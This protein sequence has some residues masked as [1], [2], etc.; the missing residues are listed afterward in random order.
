MQNVIG[1]K[2][3]E[4]LDSDYFENTTVLCGHQGM[5]HYVTKVNV[6]EVPDIINWVKPGEFLLTTAYSIRHDIHQL[7]D[8]IPL[9][10]L[11]GVAGIGIKTKRYIEELPASV[12]AT[13]NNHDFPIVGIP[14][15]L[16]FGDIIS[17]VLTS[18]VNT[19]MKLLL[20]IDD[21]N[22]RLKEIMLQGG[23]IHEIAHMIS[24][25][26]N[27][28]VAIYE[29]I[30]KEHVCVASDDFKLTIE[31]IVEGLFLKKSAKFY[32]S[33]YREEILHEVDVINN[34]RVKRLMMAICS[35]DIMY[36]HLLI[37]DI[38]ENLSDAT[39][40]MIQAAT[41]LIAL[42]SS[43]KL[44]IYENE[45]K[46][47]IE[48]IE[49][50]ISDQELPYLRALDKA[51]YFDFDLSLSYTALLV[52]VDPSY[53]EVVR[54]PNNSRM[55]KQL[56]SKLVSVVERLYRSHK[57]HMIYGAKSDRVI[58]L[59]GHERG[60]DKES[61][62]TE[63]MKIGKDLL[64]MARLENIQDKITIGIG[65]SY[66]DHRLL[67]KSYRESE[68]TVIA[69]DLMKSAKKVLHFDELG[70]YRI[71][72]NEEI[73]EDIREFFLEVLG[74]IIRYDQQKD[75]ELLQTLKMYYKCGCNLKKVSEEMY[76]HYNTIIY[77]IQRIKDIGNIDFND[78]DTALN[79][80]MAIKILDLINID[81]L[82]V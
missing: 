30:F 74:P 25:S 21:F 60:R 76:T 71:L 37:W 29:D 48:F 22:T 6:M 52:M 53:S 66:D 57:G 46:H 49:E 3:S 5:N 13:A 75:A 1:V 31:G 33:N 59:M 38:K 64:S 61:V 4:I 24:K 63:M 26:I 47:K 41:S 40:K 69:M 58:F 44:S 20:E 28:P 34:K 8:L 14:M 62:K 65:R 78:P 12:M 35:D 17:N 7:N 81:K 79:V 2:L 72:S 15:D 43:K 50:L 36:G 10:K 56:N 68:K 27:A 45:N 18:V 70:I 82:N 42:N 51:T 16:S 32:K 54:T 80:H 9:M 77:R 67:H 73:K 19:Q 55:L 11:K 23:G 39:L